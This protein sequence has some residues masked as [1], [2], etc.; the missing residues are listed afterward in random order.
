MERAGRGEPRAGGGLG[1]SSRRGVDRCPTP[2]PA[3]SPALE[4]RCPV[5]AQ[6]FPVP[7]S[8]PAGSEDWSPSGQGRPGLGRG[9]GALRG[10]WS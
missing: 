3:A 7:A 5:L 8:S 4:G 2:P 9:W 6:A 1:G 10:S